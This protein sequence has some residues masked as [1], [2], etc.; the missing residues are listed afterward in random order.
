[1]ASTSSPLRRTSL[2]PEHL[3]LGA[4]MVPFAG[5][6][7]PVQYAGIL[8][9]HRSV[10]NA[11]G[12]FD[13]SHMGEFRVQG[14]A[15]LDF[16]QRLTPNDLSS[17]PV[18]GSQYSSF[19][20]DDGGML[21]DIFIYRLDDGYLVVVNAANV[22]KIDAWLVDHADVNARV[23]NVSDETA[24]VAVQGPL[25]V[26]TV[27]QL[28]SSDLSTLPRRGIRPDTIAGVRCLAART[29]YTGEDGLELFC[30][31]SDAVALWQELGEV[32]DRAI[33]PCGLGARDTLRLE[34]GNLLYGHDMDESINPLEAGLGFTVK[35]DKGEFLGRDALRRAATEGTARRLIGFE[36][37]EPGVARS[38]CPVEEAG[39]EVGRVTS[40]SF[41][42]TLERSIGLAYVPR[43]LAIVGQ[44][45][46]VVIRGRR[47]GAKVV[48]LPFYRAKNRPPVAPA[49]AK[50]ST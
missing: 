48:K 4:R 34:A 43:E 26:Q 16:L 49:A 42:P 24:L 11:V 13:V 1:M 47:T 27:Q 33:Q 38:D 23:R 35:L 7:M 41:S 8:Q 37:A 12:M 14:A 25:A 10:R 30:E 18:G 21:D 20:R 17:V 28:T 32:S 15:A 50:E 39:R 22:E 40:G 9:E 6:E 31:P 36:L 29:G 44:A 5:W 19:L 2:Y 3:R 45:L 46:D